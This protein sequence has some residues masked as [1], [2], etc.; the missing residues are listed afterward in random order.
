VAA[1]YEYGIADLKHDLDVSHRAVLVS[2]G[3]AYR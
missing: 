3:Y 2:L 1:R